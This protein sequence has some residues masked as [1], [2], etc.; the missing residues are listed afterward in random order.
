VKEPSVWARRFVR[1]FGGTVPP[2][3][4]KR[5]GMT[6]G[7]RRIA[8]RSAAVLFVSSCT[9][10][11]VLDREEDERGAYLSCILLHPS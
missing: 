4:E 6:M 2:R 1:R 3:L 7:N 11:S 9:Y 8:L 10:S 5:R